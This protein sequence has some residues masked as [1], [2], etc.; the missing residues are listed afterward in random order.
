MDAKN[1]S[2]VYPDFQG[3]VDSRS[4]GRL[5]HSPVVRLAAILPLALVMADAAS[6][7]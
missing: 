5:L 3:S 1:S 7:A 4:F 6:C 2:S